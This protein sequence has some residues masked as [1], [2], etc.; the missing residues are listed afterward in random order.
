MSHCSNMKARSLDLFS[1]IG[2]FS[3]A[4]RRQVTTILYCEINP[5]CQSVLRHQM[6]LGHL[7]KAP[8]WDDVCTLPIE[9]L[10][11]LKPQLIT[12]GFP[13]QDVSV[14]NISAT[15]IINSRTELTSIRS[16]R[17]R[18]V[19]GHNLRR[20]NGDFTEVEHSGQGVIGCRKFDRRRLGTRRLEISSIKIS[21]LQPN[22]Q[23]TL[24]GRVC[25]RLPC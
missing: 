22:R 12:A 9:V 17:C 24:G 1:G 13:C 19:A 25:F 20:H 21:P 23:A 16:R 8:I 15:E 6:A 3:L 2:G 10:N 4:L 14:A 7:D 18:T 5:E 11:K